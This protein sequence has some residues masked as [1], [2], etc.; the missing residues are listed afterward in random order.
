MLYVLPV[1]VPRQL[2]LYLFRRRIDGGTPRA[3]IR[4]NAFVGHYSLAANPGANY[5]PSPHDSRKVPV[6]QLQNPYVSKYHCLAAAFWLYGLCTTRTTFC[7][8]S[9]DYG[10][11][12]TMEIAQPTNQ[13]TYLPI[14][15]P[16]NQTI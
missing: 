4:K 3:S 10:T 6:M 12:S 15:H 7:C 2:F 8:N 9:F 11:E 14:T 13:P 16:P 5:N 1:E